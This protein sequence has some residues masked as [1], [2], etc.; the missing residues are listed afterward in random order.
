[1]KVTVQCDDVVK[2]FN[3][4]TKVETFL[5][6]DMFENKIV[7]HQG[8]KKTTLKECKINGFSVEEKAR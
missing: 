3:D 1:M 7:I 5:G 6:F 2:F 4:V 8:K